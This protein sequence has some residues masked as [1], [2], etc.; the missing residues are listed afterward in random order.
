[1]QF[2]IFICA[3]IFISLNIIF[4]LILDLYS[5]LS[6]GVNCGIIIF[7]AAILVVLGRSKMETAFKISLSGLFSFLGLVMFV[8]G[9]LLPGN[10]GEVIALPPPALFVLKLIGPYASVIESLKGNFLVMLLCLI[11]AFE[12]IVFAV[13]HT[14][15]KLN[16]GRKNG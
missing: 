7:T 15:S 14:V 3:F 11:V 4:G 10:L 6:V 13:C 1:M 9:I 8:L 16:G 12:I 5:A 2:L